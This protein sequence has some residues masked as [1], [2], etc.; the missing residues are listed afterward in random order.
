M[1]RHD[2]TE[3]HY[4]LSD[5]FD[6]LAVARDTDRVKH[7]GGGNVIE[8]NVVKCSEMEWNDMGWDEMQ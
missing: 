7:L 4:L 6:R 5:A 1:T 2:I 3:A 8:R